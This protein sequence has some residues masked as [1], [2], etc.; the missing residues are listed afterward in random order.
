[1]ERGND[2]QHHD[3]NLSQPKTINLE[4]QYVPLKTLLQKNIK[5]L[6]ALK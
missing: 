4:N 5:K 2:D 1:M 3:L 6:G